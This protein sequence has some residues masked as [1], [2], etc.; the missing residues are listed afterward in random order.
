LLIKDLLLKLSRNFYKLP[1]YKFFIRAI[2]VI[3][4][5]VLLC[6]YPLAKSRNYQISAELLP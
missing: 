6:S 5:K 2:R 1:I 4:G 3:R